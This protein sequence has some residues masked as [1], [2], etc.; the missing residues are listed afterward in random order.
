MDSDSAEGRLRVYRHESPLGS[1]RVASWRV[2]PRLE[3]LVLA[4]WF[5]EGRVAY[6]R[7]R[8]LPSGQS[9]L[10]IN[11]GPTQYRIA[12]GPPERRIAFRDVWYAALQQSPIDTEAPEGNALLGVAFA[13]HGAFPFLACPQSELAGSVLPL[14]DLMGGGVENLRQSL[15]AEA[16]LARRF[17]RLESWLLGRLDAGAA[18][19]PAVRWCLREMARHGGQVRVERLA[20]ETGYSRKYL[21]MLFQHQVGYAPKVLARIERFRRALAWLS[22]RERFDWAELAQ[23]CG[24]YD[25]SHLLRDFRAFTGYAPSD[26]LRQP[27]PDSL[28]VV[29]D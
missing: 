5:G 4:I 15:L 8:I 3:G 18:T 25:Q 13:A 16:D 28:S 6:A 9:Q 29:V 19:H 2:H 23:R 20:Q 27:R 24:Y 26:F 14:A 10:L 11:L 21:A 12:A 22:E 7:D 17:R 1:W